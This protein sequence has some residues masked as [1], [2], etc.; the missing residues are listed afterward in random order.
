MKDIVCEQHNHKLLWRT[1]FSPLMGDNYLIL[2]NQIE[3]HDEL[4]FMVKHTAHYFLYQLQFNP[5]IGQG[6]HAQILE[7]ECQREYEG[8]GVFPSYVMKSVIEGRRCILG[9]TWNSRVCEH[10]NPWDVDLELRR[11]LVGTIHQRE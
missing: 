8:K 6:W 10:Y 3:P 7:V 5:T 4:Y 2:T 1:W 9:R 11:W